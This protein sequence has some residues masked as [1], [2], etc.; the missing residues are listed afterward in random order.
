MS[1]HNLSN[2]Q[3]LFIIIFLFIIII[4]VNLTGNGIHKKIIKYT[5]I[6]VVSLYY[7]MWLFETVDSRVNKDNPIKSFFKLFSCNCNKVNPLNFNT[8]T[9]IY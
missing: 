8:V 4:I 5:G 9:K 2:R 6:F 3:I 7:T 1:G